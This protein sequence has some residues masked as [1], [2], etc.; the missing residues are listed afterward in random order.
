VLDADG[1]N[2]HAGQLELL[3]ERQGP[4]VLTPHAGELARLLDAGS[5]EVS[6]ARLR[7]VE[8]AAAASEAIVLLKGD[9]T[10]VRGADKLAVNGLASPALATAGTG[11]VLSGMIAAMIARGTEPFAAVCAAVR[12]H[13]RAG[14]LA[15]E[16]LGSAESV[17]AGDVIEAIPAALQGRSGLGSWSDA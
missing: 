11:D 15:A 1:L 6:A 17:I 7:S 14:R 13:A 5:D 16:R 2:A 3:A 9:D 8:R 12:A 4:T 10:L